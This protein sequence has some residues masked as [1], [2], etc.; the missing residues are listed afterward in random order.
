M[1][2][3]LI[4]VLFVYPS[5]VAAQ[6]SSWVPA[7]GPMG[8]ALWT[9]DLGEGLVIAVGNHPKGAW[10]SDDGGMTWSLIYIE[11]DGYET[12]DAMVR[13]SSGA[14]VGFSMTEMYRSVD[15][16]LSWTT[17]SSALGPWV[18][19]ALALPGRIH[20]IAS[21]GVVRTSFDDGFTWTNP[22]NTG[23]SHG[24]LDLGPNGALWSTGDGGAYRSLDDGLTWQ[25]VDPEITGAVET[26]VSTQTHLYALASYG[27]FRRV[28][29]HLQQNNMLGDSWQRISYIDGIVLAVADD[30]M[31]F[32][33]GDESRVSRSLDGGET[34]ESIPVGNDT[35]YELSTPL[36]GIVLANV[37]DNGIWTSTSRGESWSLTGVPSCETTN[38]F[39]VRTE[40]SPLRLISAC[41]DGGSIFESMNAGRTWELISTVNPYHIQ[42]LVGATEAGTLFRSGWSG[43]TWRSTDGGGTWDEIFDLGALA[44]IEGPSDGASDFFYAFMWDRWYRSED[45]GETWLEG[46]YPGQFEAVAITPNGR[47]LLSSGPTI[48]HSDDGGLTWEVPQELLPRTAEALA[49]GDDGTVYAPLYSSGVY[50]SNDE[51]ETWE[52]TAYERTY[53]DGDPFA[54]GSDGVAILADQNEVYYTLDHGSTWTWGGEAVPRGDWPYVDVTSLYVTTDGQVIAGTDG[55]GVYTASIASLPTTVASLD[56]VSATSVLTVRPNPVQTHADVGLDLERAQ[57]GRIEV[58]DALGRVT[59]VLHDGPLQRGRQTFA[60]DGAFLPN[61]TYLVR[62]LGD[63]FS[64][65]EMITIVH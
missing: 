58:L 14:I 2:C 52:R 18:R 33:V 13:S 20:A 10:R 34:W 43:G 39:P 53:Y 50:R 49:V 62:F 24:S 29:D 61:G 23:I 9:Y 48:F 60:L 16:G 7:Q 21:N 15:D 54:A 22:V 41:E 56:P 3:V 45:E 36:P 12:P 19:D 6:G 11:V 42:R 17:Q 47:I 51:G 57:S 35:V 55:R 1:R 8:E 26:L 37:G 31:T 64:A 28:P 32:Y 65:V 30:G 59:A 5:L 38:V 63:R 44:F 40:S 27:L 25:T 4:V 46:Q